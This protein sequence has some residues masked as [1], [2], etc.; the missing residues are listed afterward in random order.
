M[1]I[2]TGS[3]TSC[4]PSQKVDK[5]T[6]RDLM[7]LVCETSL[8]WGHANAGCWITPDGSILPCDYEADVHHGHIVW[9]HFSEPGTDDPDDLDVLNLHA[10]QHGWIR[11]R[12][13]LDNFFVQCNAGHLS[14]RAI[15]EIARLDDTD[16]QTAYV[17]DIDGHHTE[18]R[19]LGSLLAK[20]R[21]HA[22]T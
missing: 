8:P 10:F 14:R 15:G 13:T 5:Y 21:E 4:G 6:M 19:S 18:F 9:D 1:L 7:N 12:M 3:Y 2:C 20:L 11:V 22:S 16:T 17:L